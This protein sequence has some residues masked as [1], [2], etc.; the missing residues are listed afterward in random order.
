VTNTKAGGQFRDERD[1]STPLTENREADSPG[2]FRGPVTRA[3]RALAPDLARGAMLLLIAL[4][5][6]AV[7]IFGREPGIRPATEAGPL[8]DAINLVMLTMVNARAYPVFAFM[9]GYGIVQLMLRQ[10][11]AGAS[12]PDVRGL[13]LRRH[14]WMIVVGGTHAMLLYAGDIVSVYGLLGLAITLLV[15]RRRERTLRIV[16]GVWMALALCGTLVSAALVL[17]AMNP[18][19]QTS[20]ILLGSSF[21]SLTAPDYWSG[22][23]A[24]A[25]EWP[26]RA[27][28]GLTF[29]PVVLLGVVAA[30]HRVLEEPARHQRLLLGAVLLGLPVAFLGGLP[31]ALASVGYVGID[32]GASGAAFSLHGGSGVFAG[33]GYAALF[34]LLALGVRRITTPADFGESARL[35]RG[36]A[37]ALAAL[38]QRSLSG[39]L[40]QSVA[41]ILLLSP[42]SL[43]LGAST[44][45]P[46]VTAVVVAVVVWLTTVASATALQRRSMPGPAEWLLRRLVYRPER[47]RHC[48]LARQL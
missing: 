31:V 12:W 42:Y 14:A 10:K 38:G 17:A 2:R 36:G 41:W 11:A 48:P 45:E 43:A 3:E 37:S 15:L 22:L 9:F 27:A 6:S 28:L 24:R 23:L 46:T 44:G 4:V 40:I 18:P 19:T 35:V 47:P 26:L 20:E 1:G 13:L 16:V 39:Y 25:S 29:L 32:Q 5:N 33:P 30:H 21:A 7:F 34:A 8:D